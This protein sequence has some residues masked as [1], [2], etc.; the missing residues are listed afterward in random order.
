MQLAEQDLEAAAFDNVP[1]AMPRIK[2][3]INGFVRELRNEDLNGSAGTY[4]LRRELMKRFNLV[5]APAKVDAV[6]IE[7]ML[8]Q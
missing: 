1:E 4:R 3:Q 7:G 5:M 6:L 8:I 2:D